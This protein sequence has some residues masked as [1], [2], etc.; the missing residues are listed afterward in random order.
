M[1]G[2]LANLFLI[3]YALTCLLAGTTGLAAANWEMDQVFGLAA[4][5]IAPGAAA[6]LIGQYRFLKAL[7]LAFGA[8]L[9]LYRR[10]ILDGAQ[11]ILIFLLGCG[12][13]LAARII[14]WWV[15]G[16]PSAFFLAVLVAEAATLVLVL[17]Y[18]RRDRGS[19]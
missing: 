19:P 1:I 4:G 9:L 10:D 15:D 12:L 18:S 16:R 5:T 2:M 17:G 7:E 11:P 6:D 14:G 13:G 8:F 3:G